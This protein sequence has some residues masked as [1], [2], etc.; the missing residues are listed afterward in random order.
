VVANY[1][2]LKGRRLADIKTASGKIYPVGSVVA[3]DR[4]NDLVMVSTGAVREDIAPLHVSSAMPLVGDRV[5][6]IGNP[7]GL[8]QTV[9]DGIVS[10]Y[11]ERKGGMKAIQITAPISPGSSGSP[12]VNL[13]GEVIGVAFGHMVGGQNLNFCIPGEIVAR[14]ASRPGFA[15]TNFASQ[16]ADKLYCY[17][18][19]NK[20]VHFVKNPDNVGSHYVL[21][22][23]SDGAPDRDRFEKWVLEIFGNPSKIDPQAEVESEKAR[24]PEHFRKIFPGY[25]LEQ[26]GRFA[27]EARAYWGSWG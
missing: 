5:V 15:P 27:P 12:V 25:E 23:G 13:Q 2:A 9:S 6:V 14:L 18:D 21:L 8:E 3:E 16:S 17:L 22:T 11:R 26:L 10:A 24:L 19:E 20:T 7:L 4:D 1:H